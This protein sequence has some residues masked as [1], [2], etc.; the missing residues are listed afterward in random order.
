MLTATS[1][2]QP[3]SQASS[4]LIEP[5]CCIVLRKTVCTDLEANCTRGTHSNLVE[6]NPAERLF[7]LESTV[8]TDDSDTVNANTE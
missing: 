6:E 1:S 5:N 4:V 7:E 3:Q 2:Y 8:H